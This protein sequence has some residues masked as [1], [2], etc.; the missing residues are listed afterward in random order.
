MKYFSIISF[1]CI[2]A[3]FIQANAIMAAKFNK[4]MKNGNTRAKDI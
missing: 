2:L 1:L 3:I 4:I